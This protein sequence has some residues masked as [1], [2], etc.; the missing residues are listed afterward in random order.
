[1]VV[2]G[3]RMDVRK[4]L[5]LMKGAQA[6]EVLDVAEGEPIPEQT[7]ASEAEVAQAR[8]DFARE[9]ERRR[10]GK[11]TPRK[12]ATPS[13][14]PSPAPVRVN[15]MRRRLSTR[16][17]PLIL[18][19]IEPRRALPAYVPPAPPSIA[20]GRMTR[21]EYREASIKYVE[22]LTTAERQA[23][24][25]YSEARYI[26]INSALRQG[27]PIPEVDNARETARLIDAA[28]AKAKPLERPMTFE[29][30]LAYIMRGGEKVQLKVGDEYV[31]PAYVS[32]TATQFQKL[33][34]L[35]RKKDIHMRVTVPA[36]V[37][38][39]LISAADPVRSR[40]L[41]KS[42]TEALLPRGLRFRVTGVKRKGPL[43]QLIDVEVIPA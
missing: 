33:S 19:S 1:M 6:D 34:S 25:A 30:G 5:E 9:Q 41:L 8:K 35:F 39:G 12:P 17:E 3:Q 43:K 15:T 31:D 16:D 40:S 18:P 29:R 24:A 2:N 37:R 38:V 26:P 7:L 13:S 4:A 22:S 32:T 20:P 14:T 28:I 42:E 21:K 11:A 10:A 36:G 23:L 27:I